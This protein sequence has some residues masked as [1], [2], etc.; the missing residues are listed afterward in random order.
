MKDNRYFRFLVDEN[1]PYIEG[2][3]EPFGQVTYLDQNAFT[4]SL[5]A[6]AD[7]LIIRTR[8]RCNE[9][10]LAQTPVK[11]VATATIGMDQIDVPWCEANGITVRNSP[12]CNAPAVA[13]YVWSS[14]LRLG[15]DPDR[16]TLGIIGCGNVGGIV[17]D[18]GE[19]LGAH[20]LVN[21]PFKPEVN[22]ASVE[23]I[24][25]ECDA[26]T[27]HTPLTKT[28]ADPSFHLISRER[29]QG[30]K[31]GAIFINAAR[32]PVVDF[33]AL[34]DVLSERSD[35]K[36]AI[37]TWEGEPAVDPD[38]VSLTA[39]ATPHIA[40]YSRQGKERATRMV[41]EAV[42][43]TFGIS[44]DKTGLCGPY[45]PPAQLSAE[46]ILTSYDPGVDD[47][48]LRGNPSAFESLRLNYNYREETPFKSD[49]L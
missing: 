26:V 46:E 24:I 3:L 1:I 18:W 45:I 9:A 22:N 48:A 12:G 14:L 32:G 7:A 31:P 13:Q 11:L 41:L 10:L 17:K 36:A 4:P 42:E 34:K 23:Q 44:V 27:L 47:A 39:Y 21:D 29:L 5:A 15:F 28:G 25:A 20:L 6:E 30:L 43:D 37:D 49:A 16:H 40:G 38:L 33:A 19:K 35:I 2:R 8:T